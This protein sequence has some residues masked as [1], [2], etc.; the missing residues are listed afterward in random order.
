MV[1]THVKQFLEMKADGKGLGYWSEQA[2]ESVHA[3]FKEMWETVK[4]DIDHPEFLT[5]LLSCVIRWN[6]RHI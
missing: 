4:V 6:S 3:D 2:F 1:M 5:K